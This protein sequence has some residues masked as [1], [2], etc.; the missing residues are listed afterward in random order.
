M[1]I[2]GN[3][4]LKYSVLSLALSASP[5]LSSAEATAEGSHPSPSK[6]SSS[7]E[8]LAKWENLGKV[9]LLPYM[10][11]SFRSGAKKEV[12]IS[13]LPT[14]ANKMLDEGRYATPSLWALHT[15]GWTSY[16][17]KRRIK[18]S[19]ELFLGMI[20]RPLR[21]DELNLLEPAVNK[22]MT[23][24][25][26]DGLIL[27]RPLDDEL[28]V[29]TTGMNLSK[30]YGLTRAGR[31]S[32][33]TT[34]LPVFEEWEISPFP[35]STKITILSISLML[36]TGVLIS[37]LRDQISRQFPSQI[38]HSVVSLKWVI[39]SASFGWLLSAMV[40]DIVLWLDLYVPIAAVIVAIISAIP[41]GASSCPP[42]LRQATPPSLFKVC[43][44]F[45][46]FV[47]ASTSSML[48][49]LAVPVVYGGYA[50]LVLALAT[51]ILAPQTAS[52]FGLLEAKLSLAR[53]LVLVL[54][55][56]SWSICAVVFSVALP[57]L[58]ESHLAGTI[59]PPVSALFVFQEIT[60]AVMFLTTMSVLV[61][62]VPLVIHFCKM[63]LPRKTNVRSGT[64]M[65]FLAKDLSVL[66][67]CV[68]FSLVASST[69]LL[70]GDPRRNSTMAMSAKWEEALLE[71]KKG[72]AVIVDA[73]SPGTHPEIESFANL[74]PESPDDFLGDFCSFA[75][76]KKVYVFCATSSCDISKNLARRMHRLCPSGVKYIEGGAETWPGK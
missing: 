11:S 26:V 39:A 67:A 63:R 46:I 49:S 2:C 48:A 29:V 1:S 8:S 52:Y 76:G 36:L 14:R 9:A 53:S 35:K 21:K 7:Y 62:S 6:Q 42:R 41:A 58:V 25:A 34:S 51:S 32:A 73:R 19:Q 64:C 27:K 72:T 24:L 74:D 50:S 28:S 18:N 47:I 23:W 45:S 43:N 70:N 12:E 5:T 13:E 75:A 30:S 16:S 37:I 65:G 33:A 55:F 56:A 66:S 15:A 61:S 69:S 71:S 59:K 3:K 4:I 38:F 10:E 17:V 60:P 44:L 68:V 31:A 54:S 57:L 22:D 20:Q 40:P